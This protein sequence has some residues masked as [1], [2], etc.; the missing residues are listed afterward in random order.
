MRVCEGLYKQENLIRHEYRMC[1]CAQP[2]GI[3]PFTLVAKDG[4]YELLTLPT[5]EVVSQWPSER[6]LQLKQLES[7]V[8]ALV[9]ALET[10]REYLL[11]PTRLL[12]VNEGFMF[13]EQGD[14]K[15]I[16]CPFRSEDDVDFMEAMGD[17]LK[18]LKEQ[19]PL[20]SERVVHLF[21][22]LDILFGTSRFDSLEVEGL[23]R[24]WLK[25]GK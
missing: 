16:Y 18:G 17:L 13:D 8:K 4:C 14:I 12:L 11:E 21:H 24:Q 9:Q 25:E 22:T 1:L 20:G 5:Y 3:V 6:Y 2:E 19:A 15:V 7:I 23:L 10:C